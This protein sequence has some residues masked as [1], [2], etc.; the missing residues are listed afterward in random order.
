MKKES[1]NSPIG[2][3][4][5]ITMTN[6]NG[7]TVTLSNLGAG[8]ISV[9]VPD[10]NGN[11][12]DVALGYKNV[13]D[14]IQDGPNCGKTPGRFA[15]RI[16][17]GRFTLNGKTYSLPVN[18]EPNH[19]HGGNEGFANKLWTVESASD[20]QVVFS[21]ISP[22]GDMGYPGTVHATAT[23]RWSDLNTLEVTYTAVTDKPTVV[24]LTNHAYWNLNGEGT[25]LNH[26]LQINASEYLVTDK[27][28]T[29]T[30]EITDVEGTPLDFITPKPIGKD[31]KSDFAPLKYAN[32]Y[33]HCFVLDYTNRDFLQT[34]ASLT[35]DKSGITMEVS[36]NAPAL[37]L[38]TGNW[39][40]GAPASRTGKAFQAYDGV[41]LE[42]QSYP[43]APNH[44]NFPSTVLNP[45]E[46]YVNTIVFSFSTI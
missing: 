13:T 20:R 37:M 45:G 2:E 36:T 5:L 26:I 34:E 18:L 27:N 40:K 44:G 46:T 19:L 7:A 10:R 39:L 8:I 38:Y 23:Y 22:D 16:A 6:A 17:N 14:Y 4:V 43:D 31:I 33:D 25:I 42:C 12:V 21:L 3:I 41:A 32:G 35:S 30:G 24:N 15:N 9:I 1:F 28:L 29:P 11:P